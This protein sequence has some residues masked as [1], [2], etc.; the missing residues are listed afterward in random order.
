MTVICF[1]FRLHSGEAWR[2][3]WFAALLAIPTIVSAVHILERLMRATGGNSGFGSL[4]FADTAGSIAFYVI[5]GVA[6]T[7]Y[8]E[9]RQAPNKDGSANATK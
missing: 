8:L 7:F 6:F 4:E 5:V 3:H 9:S 2:G 1:S